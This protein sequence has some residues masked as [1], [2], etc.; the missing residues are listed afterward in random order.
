MI[1]QA[2]DDLVPCYGSDLILY[3][4]LSYPSLPVTLASVFFL[5]RYLHDLLPHLRSLLN[6][7]SIRQV[8]IDYPI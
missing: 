5:S 6:F 8:F 2:L 1:S 4:S 3:P 7:H